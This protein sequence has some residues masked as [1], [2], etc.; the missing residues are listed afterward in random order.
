MK[1]NHWNI[2]SLELDSRQDL[3]Q[4]KE[5]NKTLEEVMFSVKKNSL[6]SSFFFF[7]YLG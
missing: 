5:E 3:I 2:F 7:V 6:S 1:L 4:L